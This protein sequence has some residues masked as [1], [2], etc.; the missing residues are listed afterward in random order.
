MFELTISSSCS[1]SFLIEKL[2]INLDPIIKD[3]GG[4]LVF[5]LFDGRA[6]MTLAVKREKKEYIKS[7]VISEIADVII[8]HYKYKF[9]MD[10]ISYSNEDEKETLVKALTEF[11]KSTDKDLAIKNIIFSNNLLLDSLYHFK[12]GELISNNLPNLIAGDCLFDMMKFLIKQSP[13]KIEELYIMDNKDEV[14]LMKNNLSYGGLCFKKSSR[15]FE[16]DIID[17][18]ISLAPRKIFITQDAYS[19]IKFASKIEDLFEGKVYITR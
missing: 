4:I 15:T 3:A 8:S 16:R 5:G 9:L 1:E 6:T 11:D 14:V 13:P 12:L 10:R 7:V 17:N 19:K 18:L 2:S